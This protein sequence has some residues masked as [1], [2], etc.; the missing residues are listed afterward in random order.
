MVYKNGYK[1]DI[2]TQDVVNRYTANETIYS[3]AK[4]YN[5]SPSTIVY[6][7][8][9]A[10]VY[11]TK[12]K[13]SSTKTLNKVYSEKEIMDAVQCIIST[14]SED[15]HRKIIVDTIEEALKLAEEQKYGEH[16][17]YKS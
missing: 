12:D 4:S 8:R 10:G 13:S 17:R 5:V 3:I 6:R 1:E 11:V 15:E 7:L 14:K 16:T 9:K 2:K